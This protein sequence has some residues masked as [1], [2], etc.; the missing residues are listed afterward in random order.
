MR[1]LS[2]SYLRRF[3]ATKVC[4]SL[5]LVSEGAV[6]L[7]RE[8]RRGVNVISEAEEEGVGEA[9]R[10]RRVSGGG[11][12]ERAVLDL[13]RGAERSGAGKGIVGRRGGALGGLVVRWG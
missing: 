13:R 5:S 1:S 9:E 3:T 6:R 12:R 2:S 10:E 7:L 8:M 11:V 4:R